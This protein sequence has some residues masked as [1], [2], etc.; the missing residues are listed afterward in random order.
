MAVGFDNVKVGYAIVR[1][2]VDN[3]YP[4]LG[5]VSTTA[6]HESREKRARLRSQGIL[7]A[8]EEAGLPTPVRASVPDPL[9]IDACGIIAAD[10]VA[11]SPTI[12]AAVCA[13]EIIGIGAL[14]ELQRRGWTVPQDIGIAGIGDANF[15][16]LVQPGLTTVHFPGYVIGRRA[17]ELILSRLRGASNENDCVDVGFEVIERGSTQSRPLA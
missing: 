2:L 1:H 13:N 17:A 3:G 4:R 11:A 5:Y 16:A 10:F 15:T 6:E 8:V 7:Q 9:D 12:D 14:V